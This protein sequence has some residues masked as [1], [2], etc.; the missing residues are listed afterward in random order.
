L[1]RRAPIILLIEPDD[2]DRMTLNRMLSDRGYRV[3]AASRGVD[4]LDTFVIHHP[5]IALV[6]SNSRLPDIGGNQ[7][8][9]ALHRIDARV[10][11]VISRHGDYWPDSRD[12]ASRSFAFIEL[13]AD[14]QR[15][16]QPSTTVDGWYA[17]P[18]AGIAFTWPVR[19]DELDEMEGYELDDQ[20]DDRTAYRATDSRAQARVPHGEVLENVTSPSD[21]LKPIAPRD[22]RNYLA[23]QE[24]ARRLR[25]RRVVRIGMVLATLIIVAIA[26]LTEIRA[27]K[28][29]RAIA[30]YGPTPSRLSATSVT[31]QFGT[32]RLISAKRVN[33]SNVADD[34]R[35]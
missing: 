2:T 19:D 18:G 32:V 29:R 6:L 20:F 26:V 11:V 28:T 15:R 27:T 23:A 25:L 24:S 7:L 13:L 14:V 8:C 12:S 31:P 3:M 10:P 5:Q 16:L 21:K 34:A 33:S 30:Q 9:G 1:D 17:T 22:L 4:A 35:R